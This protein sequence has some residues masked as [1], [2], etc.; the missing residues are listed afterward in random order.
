MR[1]GTRGG[2]SSKRAARRPSEA[3]GSGAGPPGPFQGRSGSSWAPRPSRRPGKRRKGAGGT[4][5]RPATVMVSAEARPGRGGRRAPRRRRRGLRSLS[6]T[7]RGSGGALLGSRA[8][9]GL[10]GLPGGGAGAEPERPAGSP[11][12]KARLS[13]GEGSGALWLA[14]GCSGSKDAPPPSPAPS[15]GFEEGFTKVR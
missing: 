14:R 3:A 13:P 2:R 5:P 11:E 15:W 12:G 9:N 6:R 4:R 10:T 8:W 7:A 1:P